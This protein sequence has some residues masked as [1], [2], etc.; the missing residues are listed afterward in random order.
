MKKS[1]CLAAGFPEPTLQPR[2]EGSRERT[3][4]GREKLEAAQSLLLVTAKSW[5][6]SDGSFEK[7]KT[8]QMGL[9]RRKKKSVGQLKSC[10]KT[11]GH[12]ASC[13]IWRPNIVSAGGM[14]PPF[15]NYFPKHGWDSKNASPAL[16]AL[17]GTSSQPVFGGLWDSNP[18]A[19]CLHVGAFVLFRFTVLLCL[20]F[21]YSSL[22]SRVWIRRR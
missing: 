12:P 21:C 15:S 2:M 16:V 20:E 8:K 6:K 22:S 19:K 10:L 17:R 9:L 5:V 11:H 1:C 13:G 3:G 4:S 18:F 7:G 14:L